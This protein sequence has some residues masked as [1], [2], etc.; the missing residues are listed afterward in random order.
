MTQRFEYCKLV[1]T[2]LA[3]RIIY[4]GHDS[5]F[6]DKQDRIA[7]EFRAWDRLEKEGWE[8]VSVVSD[9]KMQLVA[10]FKRSVGE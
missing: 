5:I 3:Y 4:L 6:E 1:S 10:Y 9:P 7:N 8:L 2:G